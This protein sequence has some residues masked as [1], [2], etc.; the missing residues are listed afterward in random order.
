VYLVERHLFG[1]RD[2]EVPDASPSEKT[3][4][5]AFG[6][7]SF[8]YRVFVVTAILLF[9]ATKFFVLGILLAVFALVFWL[10]APLAKGAHFLLS[11][12]R[13]RSVRGRALVVT[14]LLIAVLGGLIALVPVPYRTMTEG[15]V[16]I[17]EEA[18][19][20]AGAEGFVGRVVVASGAPV[21]AG[22]LL[23][24]LGNPLLETDERVLVAR[25]SELRARY[26]Q[27]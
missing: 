14:V 11:S 15:V 6:I 10:V 9:V 21:E 25:I 27:N 19:V 16:W 4:F 18:L 12:P 23:V 8:V 17:P 24:E 13:L 20:R 26:V 3:W 1:S 22:T 2:A 7:L 5:V